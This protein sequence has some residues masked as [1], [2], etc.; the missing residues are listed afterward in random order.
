MNPR[1][2]CVER[3]TDDGGG[4]GGGGDEG[5]AVIEMGTACSCGKKGLEDSPHP[6]KRNGRFSGNE[7]TQ[8]GPLSAPAN[9][10]VREEPAEG[11][12]GGGGGGGKEAQSVELE[13]LEGEGREGK[14]ETHAEGVEEGG[15]ETSENVKNCALKCVSAESAVTASP[16]PAADSPAHSAAPA[17]P[18]PPAVAQQEGSSDNAAEEGMF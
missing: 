10:H 7:E 11:R 18:P 14:N 15:T 4:G 6:E 13:T 17:E 2:P 9:G 3:E 16:S 8:N 1:W 12:T 5:G